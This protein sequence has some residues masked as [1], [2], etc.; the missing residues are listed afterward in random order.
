MEKTNI[1]PFEIK[2]EKI[3]DAFINSMKNL[4]ESTS[5]VLITTITFVII[6]IAFIFYFYYSGLRSKNCSLMD[7]VYGDLNGKIQSS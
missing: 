3:K 6:L 7:S 2:P 5:V 1:T 4:K